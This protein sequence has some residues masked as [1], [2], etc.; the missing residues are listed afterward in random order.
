MSRAGLDLYTRASAN[1]AKAGCRVI[2]LPGNMWSAGGKVYRSKAE[3]ETAAAKL[4]ED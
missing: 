3:A 2:T 4:A 1:K